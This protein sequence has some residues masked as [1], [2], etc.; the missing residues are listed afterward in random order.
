MSKTP[1][2]IFKTASPLIQR[3]IQEILKQQ[4]QTK[5]HLSKMAL[6]DLVAKIVSSS[7][8]DINENT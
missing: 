8:E 2:E 3:A 7:Q 1:D 5:S 4:K 6:V